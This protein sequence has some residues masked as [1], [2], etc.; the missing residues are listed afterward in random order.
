MRLN[1]AAWGV[2]VARRASVR[3]T[4]NV[5]ADGLPRTGRDTGALNP[6]AVLERMT[7]ALRHRG[8][9]DSGLWHDP[10]AG[11]GFGFRRL[12]IVDLSLR[13]HQPMHSASRRYVLVFN[14]EIYNFPELAQRS[15]RPRPPFSGRRDTEVL[16]AGSSRWGMAWRA[17]RI[18]RYVRHR[19]LGPR[20][21]DLA[22]RARPPRQEAALPR[23][24]TETP[25]LRLRAQG[26]A[27]VPRLSPGG[28]PGR[29]SVSTRDT[30][31]ARPLCIYKRTFKLPA[32]STLSCEARSRRCDAASCKPMRDLLVAAG[33]RAPV[34]RDPSRH[35]S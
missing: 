31:C 10:A 13:G 4:A 23:R 11:I 16:L 25:A 17:S 19:A 29:L 30:V 3:V 32:G 35:L 33:R 34:Q 20:E 24:G 1:P 22:L 28:R 26:V 7:A 8:P 6:V 15:L 9:D 14:G 18:G 27:C 5:W 12:A 2:E 21:H